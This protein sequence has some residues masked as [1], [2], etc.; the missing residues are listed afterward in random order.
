MG[1]W[2]ADDRTSHAN[3]C[4]SLARFELCRPVG[5]R[6]AGSLLWETLGLPVQNLPAW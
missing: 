1:N 2:D 4:K 6:L 5:A 3:P